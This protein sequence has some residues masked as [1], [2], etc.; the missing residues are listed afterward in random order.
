MTLLKH[1]ISAPQGACISLAAMLLLG[2]QIY[3][4]NAVFLQKRAMRFRILHVVHF[5]S[6]FFLT[7]VLLVGADGIL[8][9]SGR[10]MPALISYIYTWPIFIFAV[11]ELFA[12]ALA[13][14][15]IREIRLFRRRHLR[16]DAVKETIDL[17]PAGVCFGEASG[18]PVLINDT[19]DALAQKLTGEVP[20]DIRWLWEKLQAAANQENPV[21]AGWDLHLSAGQTA[22]D[23]AEPGRQGDSAASGGRLLLTE[24]G[25]VWQFVRKQIEIA[26]EPYTQITAVNIT[27]QY[28]MTRELEEKN[29]RLREIQE[30]MKAYSLASDDVLIAEEI[31]SARRE[32]HDEVGHALLTARYYM[33]H[34][35]RMDKGELLKILRQPNY[36]LLREA[37]WGTAED[38]P[39]SEK[40]RTGELSAPPDLTDSIIRDA[41]MIGVRVCIDEKQLSEGMHTGAEDHQTLNL[42]EIARQSETV[43]RILSQAAM[44]CAANTVKHAHGNTLHIKVRKED[45]YIFEL[46]NN[47]RPPEGEIRETGGL[48]TLRYMIE[49]AGGSMEICRKPAFLLRIRISEKDGKM[50][51][52]GDGNMPDGTV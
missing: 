28:R 5:F 39:E 1:I 35:E 4:T 2:V 30:R 47:G 43:S 36:F 45:G 14:V 32:V 34:P 42:K 25:K 51:L 23:A 29:E 27:R 24:D 44:E 9:A 31:L 20:A 19:M 16:P 46:T 10:T 15:S 26:E 33:E 3:V 41:A 37:E 40:E 17:L 18:I 8:P 50:V 48:R 49:N 52:L 7:A 11:Y 13:A 22:Q 21:T 12:A 38:A 6:L